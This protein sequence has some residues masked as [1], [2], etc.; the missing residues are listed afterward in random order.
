MQTDD[1]VAG[2]LKMKDCWVAIGYIY[3]LKT[4]I[5]FDEICR[6]CVIADIKC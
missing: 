5:C 3:V 2:Y 1:I 6:W 4:D